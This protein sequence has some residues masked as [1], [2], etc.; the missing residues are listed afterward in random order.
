MNTLDWGTWGYS[1]SIALMGKQSWRKK[2]LAAR[3]TK[4]YDQNNIILNIE[5]LLA[6]LPVLYPLRGSGAICV[7][8]GILPGR[9]N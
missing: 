8:L 2:K 5:V 9:A 6:E 7:S 3:T 1:R 4:I